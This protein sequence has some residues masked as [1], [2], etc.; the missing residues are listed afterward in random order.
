VAVATPR[1]ALLSTPWPLF[2]RPSIQLGA[3]KAFVEKE[4]PH[5]A[6][7]AHHAYL[8][9]AAALGYDLYGPISERSWL[10]ESCYAAL[11]YPEQQDAVARFWRRRSAGVVEAPFEDICRILKKTSDRILTSIP[12]HRYVLLGVSIS[13]NQLTSALYFIHR[14]K[15]HMP[16]LKVVAG[17]SACSGDM[18]RS[19]LHVFPQIDFVISGEGEKPLVHLVKS[20]IETP[21]SEDPE[22][23]AGLFSRDPE[24]TSET[25]ALSQEPN[26]DRLPMPDYREYFNRLNA[27]PP[28]KRFFPKL[29]VEMSRGCWWRKPASQGEPTGCAFCNLNIQWTGYRAK[30]HDNII[31]QLRALSQTHQILSLSFMDNLLPAKDMD[32][33]FRRIAEEGKDYRLFAEIRATTRK[34]TL[35]AMGAAGMAEVQV[36]I[37]ALSSGLLKKMNKG[38]TAIQNLEIMKNCETPGLPRLTGNVILNFPGSDPS[39]VEETLKNVAFALPFQPLKATPFWLGYGSPVWHSPKAFG[40]KR[41]RNHPFYARFFPPGVLKNLHLMIQG[42]HGEVREQERLWRPVREA[43]KRWKT[44]Y[45]S[46]HQNPKS[47]PILSYQDGGDFMIIR[48]RRPRSEDMTHRLRGTSR[49]IYL[50]CQENRSLTQIVAQFPDFGEDAVLP[51]LNMMVD[52]KLMFREGPRYLSLAV[53]LRSA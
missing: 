15:Q 8:N 11:L 42:Y 16:H 25:G 32:R 29:P 48:Q 41:V 47:G 49:K 24:R 30:S 20:L 53:P 28:E 36:G 9:V 6:V 21:D 4:L 31:T 7:D 12:W 33:L 44:A 3:L 40:I 37:E 5:V 51:F 34:E 38:T 43:L 52:K 22:P 39:D 23:M 35:A 13:L 14:I 27:L 2:N 18:G 26:L 45:W 17:G 10:S 46:L 1:M 19:L 50:F